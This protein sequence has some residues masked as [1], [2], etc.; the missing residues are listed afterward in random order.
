ML[1]GSGSR[2]GGGTLEEVTDCL[3]VVGMALVQFPVVCSLGDELS[4]LGLK[5]GGTEVVGVSTDGAVMR[6]SLKLANTLEGWTNELSPLKGTEGP[7]L[8]YL[9]PYL[10]FLRDVSTGWHRKL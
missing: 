7:E 2:T 10:C 3:V 5:F 4:V 8:L 1:S 6:G 9:S